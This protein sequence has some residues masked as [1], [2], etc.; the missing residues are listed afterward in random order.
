MEI[1]ASKS[2]ILPGASFT[3]ETFNLQLTGGYHL[4][5]QLGEG[6]FAYAIL[7]IKRNKYLVLKTFSF[8]SR[9]YNSACRNAEKIL[10]KDEALKKTYKSTSAA[11]VHNKSTLVP[12]ALFSESNKNDILSFNHSIEKD[13]DIEADD[14]KTLDA[15]NIYTI[16]H[17]F[18]EVLNKLSGKAKIHHYSTSLI[19]SILLQNKN[20]PGKLVTVNVQPAQLD[21]IVSEGRKLIFYNSFAYR[22]AEDFIYYLLFACEQLKLNP[23]TLELVIIGEIDRNSAIYSLLYKY[24]RNIKFGSR[25]ESFEYSYKFKEMPSHFYH[26]LFSQYLCV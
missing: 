22:T 20:K 23:E 6:G 14:L 25:N 18:K 17:C 5:M 3:D 26:N 10:E 12:K 16:P 2:R 4:A 11:I 9:D 15:K 1:T 13:D 24:I 19:E 21:V 8:Q 7:D